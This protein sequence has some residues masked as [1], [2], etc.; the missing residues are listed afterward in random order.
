MK[1][2][3]A[4]TVGSLLLAIA[5]ANAEKLPSTLSWTAYDVGSSGYNNAVAIGNALK[6]KMGVNLRVVLQGDDAIAIG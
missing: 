6:N 4:A 3:M 5:P 1:R 2:M